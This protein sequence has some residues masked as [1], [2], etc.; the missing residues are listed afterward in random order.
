M[1]AV[2]RASKG[3]CELLLVSGPPG[4]GKT[5][6]VNEVH[7]PLARSRGSFISGKI[8]PLQRTVPY[9]A[10]TQALRSKIEQVLTSSPSEVAVWRN[11]VLQ[12]LGSTRESSAKLYRS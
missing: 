4:I 11:R 8:D 6:L 2:E 9:A 1:A 10:L 5:T 12:A 7:R 3:A